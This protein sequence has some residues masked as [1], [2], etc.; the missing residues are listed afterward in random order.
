MA[1]SLI[2][3]ATG[4][5]GR[6]LLRD[7]ALDGT[8]LA[9]IARPRGEVSAR[10]RIG[11]ILSRWEQQ[12]GYALPR[13]VVLTGD[14]AQPNLG[15]TSSNLAWISEHCDSLIH[16][17]AS[18]KFIGKDPLREPWRSNLTGT[19][20]VLDVCESTGIRNCHYVSTAYVCGQRTGLIR[21]HELDEG[22]LPGN[23]YEASKIAA[24]KMVRESTQLENVT[25][26]RPSIIAGDSRTGFTNTFHGFYFPLKLSA[27]WSAMSPALEGF[28]FWALL[29]SMGLDGSETKNFVPV[30]WVSAAIAHVVSRPPLHGETYHLTSDNPVT[31][32]EMTRII[33]EATTGQSLNENQRD[34]AKA[35]LSESS[36]HNLFRT[37]MET[38][39]SYWRDDPQFCTRNTREFISDLP[40]PVVDEMMMKRW[41]RF[42]VEQKFVEPNVET[43]K[44]DWDA[45]SWLAKIGSPGRGSNS[46]G[47]QIN[48]QGGGQ[49]NVDWSAG[50]IGGIQPGIGEDCP[51]TLYLNSHTFRKLVSKQSTPRRAI[52]TGQVVCE[53]E[54]SDPEQFLE[55]LIN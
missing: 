13:P 34:T 4:L 10:Q 5:L 19:R 26:F 8:P 50:K 7:L 9:V 51:M 32:A 46:V 2:T 24:E 55:Q 36:F 25:V 43:R 39:R 15:L 52:A 53:G 23:D 33:I 17:A 22:Q 49:W 31:I 21:E 42:A 6:Y 54:I 16:N 18:L 48:G 27:A 38:Y 29:R 12:L 28:D 11:S 20:H 40:C 30:D 47:L 35:P 37:Q 3:G 1:Y 45:E 41:C 44:L 14:L